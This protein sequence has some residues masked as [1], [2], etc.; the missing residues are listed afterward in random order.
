[1]N[2]A[3][4]QS[5]IFLV[6]LS[7][8]VPSARNVR[9][10][11]STNDSIEQLAESIKA[12]GLIQNLTV[13]PVG[14][15]GKYEVVAGGRRLQAL[16]SL[17][18]QKAIAKDYDVR[19]YV[20]TAEQAVELSLVENVMREAMH[21]ADEFEAFKA[22]ADEGAMAE[23]IA[24]R[25]GMEPKRVVQRLKLANVAPD[26]F[27]RYREGKADLE[28][29]KALALTDDHYKQ[30]AAF[31][32]GNGDWQIRQFLTEGQ[33]RSDDKRVRYVTLAAYEKNGGTVARDL[34]AERGGSE[35]VTDVELLNSLVDAKLER[36]AAKLRKEG[37][38]WVEAMLTCDY[39][40][41]HSFGR[42]EDL[43]REPTTEEAAELEKLSA[44]HDEL[45]HDEDYDEEA[46]NRIEA[47]MSEI[48]ESLKVEPTDEQKAEAGAIVHIDY[49]GAAEYVRGL[50][51]PQARKALAASGL[52]AGGKE[53]VKNEV[54]D[55]LCMKLTKERT[56]ALR[57][58]LIPN[59]A[60]ALVA[61]THALALN[62]FH[63]YFGTRYTAIDVKLDDVLEARGEGDAET[64]AGAVIRA[65][66]EAIEKMLPEEPGALFAWLSQQEQAVV[67]DILAFCASTGVNAV[68]QRESN[69]K[70]YSQRS[71][72][73]SR[74]LG[75]AVSFDMSQWWEATEAN[76]LGHVSKAKVAEAVAAVAGDVDAAAIAKLP[77][78]QAVSAAQAKLAGTGWVPNLIR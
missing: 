11:A 12:V 34:F 59:P 5:E 25:F 9:K 37:W 70:T 21:P 7:S 33:V 35:Y 36:A 52:S 76:Y 17:Q 50:L 71:I 3:I 26:L 19:C 28:Q 38:G 31:G 23:Q 16:K 74:E 62:V 69:D 30:R 18:K 67:L 65:K 42:L 64:K 72:A 29:M 47:R 13:V 54:S 66:R 41:L 22:L 57:A 61:M 15:S 77:K 53:K 78:S 2:A 49:N 4:P 8:L 44:E 45:G 51:K 58:A 14:K 63:D 60:V 46:A 48:E 39:A 27:E 55:A 40:T 24:E 56:E 10:K 6:S 68:L 43:R 32:K 1:M 75:A 73:A 20:V